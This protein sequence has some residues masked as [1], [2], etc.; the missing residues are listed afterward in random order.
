MTEKILFFFSALGVFNALVLASYLLLLKRKRSMSD[1]L[2]GSLLLFLVIRVSVSCFHYF[3]AVTTDLIRFGLVANLLIGPSVL[4]TSQHLMA[5]KNKSVSQFLVH[6]GLCLLVL[7]PLWL[8][9]DFATWDWKIRFVIHTGLF[10]YLVATALRLRMPIKNFITSRPLSS[11]ERKAVIIFLA[12]S[13]IC[14]GFAVSLW[15][16]YIL[17]PLNFSVIFYLTIYYFFTHN[18]ADEKRVTQ[19]QV[20]PSA[21]TRINDKL[22]QLMEVEKLYKDPDLSLDLLAGR[23][24]ISRHLLSQVL[25]ENLQ[26][27]FHLF[28]NEYRVNEA[29]KVLETHQH[30]SIE[31]IGHEVG[32]NSRSSFFA[33]FKKKVGMT[34]ARYRDQFNQPGTGKSISPN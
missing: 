15:T 31:A 22:Q 33:A 24:A 25:N 1:Y 4:F 10:V 13:L 17:G 6:T 12:V 11:N 2:L 21:F 29:C 16:N 28:I 27:N 32:F 8:F 20:D 7:L 14:V 26:K 3:D 34:P 30:Y 18:Q 23:L 9:V 19:K 5:S